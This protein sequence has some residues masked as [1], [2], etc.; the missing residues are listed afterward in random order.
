MPKLS[1]IIPIYNKARYLADCIASVLA[2]T[3]TDFELILVNDG[4]KD[5]SG[6]IC[7]K[8]AASDGRINVYHKPNGGV[9]SA[10]NAGIDMSSGEYLG[11][12]DADDVLAGNMYEVLIKNLENFEAD[13]SICGVKRVSAANELHLKVGEE[14][15]VLTAGEALAKFFNGLILMSTY[16]KV[17]RRA[18]VDQIRYEPPLYEDTYYNFQAIL[19]SKK[20]VAAPEMLY[21]YMIRENSSSMAPFNQQ[22]MNTLQLSN[23]MIGDCEAVSPEHVTD[24]RLFSF[25]QHMFVLNLLLVSS[26]DKYPAD[27]AIVRKNLRAFDSFYWGEKRISAKYRFGY[28]LFL[29]SPRIYSWLVN[30]YGLLIKSEHIVRRN[31][32]KNG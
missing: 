30:F 5:A 3:Y 9:S 1:I 24:A 7:D 12:V 31:K 2:Q 4:S 8:Y 23:R 19:A 28:R 32:E 17:F 10:R 26:V 18:A 6:E 15:S 13:I 21:L 14:L 16:E 29:V 20:I 27:Y 25:N 11:F 22:Y